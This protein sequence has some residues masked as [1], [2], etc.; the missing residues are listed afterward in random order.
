VS[1]VY[2]CDVCGGEAMHPLMPCFL[3]LGN[4]TRE[5][6]NNFE[7]VDLC[8]HC[9]PKTRGEWKAAFVRAILEISTAPK[10]QK[11]EGG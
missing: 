9:W 7:R 1:L 11:S 2:K 4:L 6:Q 5:T 8:E 10:L 3:T